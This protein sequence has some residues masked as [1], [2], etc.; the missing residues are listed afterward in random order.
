MLD[1]TK[2]IS[3]I[4]KGIAAV[5]LAGS[6]KE[7]QLLSIYIDMISNRP[8]ATFEHKDFLTQ[9]TYQLDIYAETPQKCV[10]IA[11]AV[12]TQ[13]QLNG[14]YRDSAALMGRQR[15]MM[16]YTALIDEKYNTYKER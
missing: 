9:F 4:L 5:E 16:I 3:A 10:E 12:D 7:L 1:V 13:M 11:E 8:E 2:K 14:W 6:E 15:Y